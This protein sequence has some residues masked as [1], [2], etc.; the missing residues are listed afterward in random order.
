MKIRPT[1]IIQRFVFGAAWILAGIV[2]LIAAPTKI[3]T[4]P[5]TGFPPQVNA[6]SPDGA[7][8]GSF[9]AETQTFT[10]GIRVGLANVV[11]TNDIITGAGPGAGPS[12]NVFNS[13]SHAL[14]YSFYAFAPNFNL[15]VFVA[16][17]DVNGDGRAD[18]IVGPGDGDGSSPVVKVLSGADGITVL[19][20]FFAFDTG[21]TGGVR[22]AAGDV[23]GDGRADII[24]A[25][26]PSGDAVKVFSG[27]DQSV[28]RNFIPFPGFTGGLYVAAGD[29]NGDGFDDVIVGAG[30]GAGRVAV[31][32]GADGSVLKN[33][34]AFTSAT[35]GARVA[36]SDL[37]GDGRA[38]IIAA[39]GPG[40]P[41]RLKAFDGTTLAT[42]ADFAPY[43]SITSGVFPGAIPRFPAQSLNISTRLNVLNDDNVLI[44]GFIITGND[45]KNL[46]IRGIGP[47][48]GLPGALAD[49]VLE[50]YGSGGGTPRHE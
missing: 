37:N 34:F 43:G 14:V 5:D 42:L 7:P 26:G 17:G 50:L 9:F 8:T 41:S 12:V 33:F 36:G 35:G 11:G 30:T 19:A 29:I 32:S 28:L 15:G 20:S 44:G 18:I 6:Y 13:S 1:N 38:D 21:F 23:N 48:T 4:G 40:D 46:I 45:S 16:G 10:G 27:R 49:P 24:A 22:V 47:S 3:V 31:F 39:T 2:P 25:Q